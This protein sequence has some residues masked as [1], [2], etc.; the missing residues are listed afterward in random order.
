MVAKKSAI[1]KKIEASKGEIIKNIN[2]YVSKGDV[3]I[4]GEIK[5]N[6]NVKAVIPAQGIIY[7]EVW[8]NVKTE[9]PLLYKEERLTNNKKEVYTIKILNKTIELFNLKK[10]QQK[11]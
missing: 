1:I 2:E 11:K 3:V 9:Y 10:Y 7:G 6:D 4:S 8:Y 5:L